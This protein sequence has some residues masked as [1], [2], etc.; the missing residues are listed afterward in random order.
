[1]RAG[2]AMLTL[3]NGSRRF[4]IPAPVGGVVR[5]VNQRVLEQP[6]AVVRD[7]YGRG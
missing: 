5:R 6:D 2:D 4:A 7:P 3:A 1:L